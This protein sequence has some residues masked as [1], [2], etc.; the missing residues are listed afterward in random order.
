MDRVVVQ[1][2]GYVRVVPTDDKALT[3]FTNQYGLRTVYLKD[4]LAGG[5][6][7]HKGWQRL[8]AVRWLKH[9]RTRELVVVVGMPSNFL[10]EVAWQ[11]DDM[12]FGRTNFIKL[13]AGEYCN[14]DGY[15]LNVYKEWRLMP[16]GFQPPE[17]AAL[18]DGASLAGIFAPM[19]AQQ[20]YSP[21]LPLNLCSPAS[22]RITPLTVPS[23]SLPCW[24][25]LPYPLSHTLAGPGARSTR[26]R[27]RRTPSR[28][29][30]SGRPPS[31][32]R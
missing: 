25:S 4:L 17:V 29:H 21:R 19:P 9:E 2:P 14:G 10:K 6:K 3:A 7:E 12:P 18:G 16:R 1:P 23:C 15:T 5:R 8:N 28:P 13:L 31:R 11:R 24:L 26:P 22:A 27:R 32:P 30:P 20:V